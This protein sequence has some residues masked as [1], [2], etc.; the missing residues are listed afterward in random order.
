MKALGKDIGRLLRDR[1]GS[2]ALEFALVALPFVLLLLGTVE[3]ARL[4]LY[5]NA[6]SNAT[7]AAS[8]LFLVDPDTTAGE[9]KQ[10]MSARIPKVEPDR[11]AVTFS[12]TTV[13]GVTYRT[14][15]TTYDLDLMVP[16]LFDFEFTL[17]NDTIVP[18]L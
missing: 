12:D 7:M 17:R 6:L 3:V 14:L 9:L 1:V 8:R 4:A 18:I 15:E 5:Q 16:T 11:L 10:Q 2:S 13:G